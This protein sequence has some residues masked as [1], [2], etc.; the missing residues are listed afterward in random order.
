[1]TNVE[2][3]VDPFHCIRRGALWTIGILLRLQIGF[4]YRLQH[5]YGCCFRHSIFDSC[6]IRF[7]ACTA[8][9]CVTAYM[10]AKSPKRPST[11]KAPAASLLLPLL[12]LL[13]AERTS[14]RVG[15]SPTVDQRLFHGARESQVRTVARHPDL[16]DVQ[17]ASA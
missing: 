11:S 14:S 3:L 2:Q 9:T 6:I 13:P 10:L 7:G 1:M 15:L 4:E 17:G 8:F 12:R 5:Q 16:V